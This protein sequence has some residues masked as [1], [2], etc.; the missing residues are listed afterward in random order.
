MGR[1]DLEIL[2]PLADRAGVGAVHDVVPLAGGANNRVSRLDADA[3]SFLLKSY[4]RHPDDPRDRLGAE[5]GFAQFAW[6]RGVRGLPQP[7][8][9]EPAA[10]LG[11]FEFVRGDKLDAATNS[12][13]EQA[14][15][16]FRSVNRFRKNA[17]AAKLPRASESCLSLNDHF[18]TV[19]RRVERLTGVEEL[20]EF[21]NGNLLP[22]WER[23]QSAARSTAA[24]NCLPTD[25]PLPF[26]ERCLSPSDFGFHNAIRAADGRLRFFD[27]EYA[28]WD[29]PAKTICDFFCQPAIPAP[30]EMFERFA[31]AVA[32]EF[33]SA[34]IHLARASLLLPVYRVKWVCIML[35][36]F[37]PVGGRRRAFSGTVEELAERK[38]LQLAKAKA[39]LALV[40]LHSPARKVA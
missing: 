39:S 14:I 16:F 33:P 23:V 1:L 9:C 19:S 4:F 7:M 32:A 15:A 17:E 25:H 37:L 3:G 29:D 35:N 5:F 11:L 8:A 40:Q 36:E 22:I 21:A 20:A 31:W 10:G 30:A 27:F 13:V 24:L 2:Q 34:A 18:Y 38:T 28:G 6:E 26:G 12:D